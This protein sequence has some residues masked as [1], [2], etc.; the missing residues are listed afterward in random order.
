[1]MRYFCASSTTYEQVRSQLDRE[2]G[3]PNADTKTQTAIPPAA[4]LPV[5]SS[6][7]VYLAIQNEYCDYVLPSQMLPGLLASGAVNEIDAAAYA[8]ILPPPP[9]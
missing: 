7:R 8:A 5:D 4:E 6:G 2:W 1:M 9:F 3:Y